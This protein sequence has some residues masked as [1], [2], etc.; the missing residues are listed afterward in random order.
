MNRLRRIRT[1]AAAAAA[2]AAQSWPVS[3]IEYAIAADLE[4]APSPYPGFTKYM[5]PGAGIHGQAP[6]AACR[7]GW[8][9]AKTRGTF[10]EYSIRSIRDEA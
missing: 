4:R 1:F 7:S 9:D 5:R 10:V 2:P 6:H 8:R 3:R